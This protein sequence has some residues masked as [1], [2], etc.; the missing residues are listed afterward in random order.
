[1][2]VKTTTLQDIPKW[3]SHNIINYP[4]YKFTLMDMELLFPRIQRNSLQFTSFQLKI[5][6]LHVSHV[7]SLHITTLHN[8]SLIT[9]NPYLNSFACNYILNPL[10]RRV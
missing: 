10:S 1:V 6:S 9:L 4:Q 2:Q 5:K 3:N 8:T 7:I